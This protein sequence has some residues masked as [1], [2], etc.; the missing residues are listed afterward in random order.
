MADMLEMYYPGLAALNP[1]QVHVYLPMMSA[2]AYE[3]A[4]VEVANASDVDAVKAVLQA[5][6]DAQVNGGAWYPETIEGWKNNSR[7]VTNGNY[8]MMVAASDFQ[9]YIDAFNAL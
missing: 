3:V 1:A 2:V 6:I 8:V 4:L 5:R 9:A 7:I